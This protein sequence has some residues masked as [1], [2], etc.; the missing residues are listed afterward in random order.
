MRGLEA[1][2]AALRR[3]L[4]QLGGL[5][6]P[7]EAAA[8][9]I[10]RSFRAGGKLLAAGN[11]G[12]AAEAQHLTSELVGRL[13]PDRERGALPAVALHTDTSTLTAVANDYGYDQVFSR[14]VEAIGR[15]GDVL[16]VLSTSGASMNL[17]N[18]VAAANDHDMVTI[19]L[20]GCGV[21]P[22]HE[23][24]NHVLAVPSD[25]VHA[26]QECHL[27]LIHVLVER[28]DELMAATTS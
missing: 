16:V 18:A 7:L 10:A 17:V 25:S 15:A 1:H 3:V 11:G 12:S 20:L 2:S 23:R 4:D 9:S 13:H 8:A 21:R 28:V 26:V 6:E 5:E 24:C 27:V 19:G 22:L 14:Q